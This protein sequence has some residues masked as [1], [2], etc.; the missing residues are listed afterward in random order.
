GVRGTRDTLAARKGKIL[1]SFDFNENA[2]RCNGESNRNA[3]LKI[4]L[5]AAPLNL[6]IELQSQDGRGRDGPREHARVNSH[7]K[8]VRH[9]LIRHW[10]WRQGLRRGADR[11]ARG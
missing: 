11:L 1:T 3:P 7:P 5:T 2:I 10:T 8:L 9:W 6:L 4:V